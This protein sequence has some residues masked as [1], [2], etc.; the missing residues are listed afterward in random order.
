VQVKVELKDHGVSWGVTGSPSGGSTPDTCG[1]VLYIHSPRFV[2]TGTFAHQ[3][4]IIVIE[5]TTTHQQ[6]I[7]A[8]MC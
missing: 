8:T 7:A 4:S 5:A 6:T 3:Q 1:G 2:I